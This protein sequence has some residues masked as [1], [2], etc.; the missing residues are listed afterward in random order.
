MTTNIIILH[1]RIMKLA[2]PCS[3]HT[4]LNMCDLVWGLVVILSTLFPPD[5]TLTVDNVSRVMEK[6]EPK[7]KTQVW[8]GACFAG[9]EKNTMEKLCTSGKE[10]ECADL[11][12][13]CNP[14]SSW[15]DLARSLYCHHQVAAIEE[16]RSYL[17]PGGRGEP[18]F[19][20]VAH[21][22]L[23]VDNYLTRK[24]IKLLYLI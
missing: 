13:N 23:W 17:P 19:T 3:L 6:V 9:M 22:N 10:D 24:Q 18:H 14:Y 21:V 8:V 1:A 12:V 4:G 15:E 7:V 5:P 2:L 16:V 20:H 11:Y